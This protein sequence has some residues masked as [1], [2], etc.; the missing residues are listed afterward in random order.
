[1]YKRNSDIAWGVLHGLHDTVYLRV[2]VDG[3]IQ[4]PTSDEYGHVLD[5]SKNVFL[6]NIVEFMFV[7]H[8]LL[9]HGLKIVSCPQNA[10]VVLIMP[11]FVCLLP[12]HRK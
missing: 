1:M 2:N 4:Y 7:H 11:V 6:R 5:S 8:T 10:I 9:G 12:H 3:S